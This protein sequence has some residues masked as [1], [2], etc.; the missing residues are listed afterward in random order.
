M[1]W[2]RLIPAAALLAACLAPTTLRGQEADPQPP[3]NDSATY[4]NTYAGGFTPGSGFDLVKTAGG[5]LNVSVYGLFRYMNQYAAGRSFTDHLGQ[6]REVEPRNDVNWHRTFVWVTGFVFDPKF[7]YSIS[8]WSLPTTQQTLLFGNLQYRVSP[9]LVIGAGLGPNLT[10]RSVQGSW[11]YWAA[12][13]R[14][15]SEEFFRGGFS[16]G[17]WLTGQALP[18]LYYTVSVNNNISQLGTTQASDT[19]NLAYSGSLKWLPTTGELGPRN[20]FGDLEFHERVAT[21]F[22]VSAATS[23]ESRYSPDDQAPNASQIRLSDGVNPFEVGALAPGVTVQTLTYDYLSFD[24]AA[25]YRGFSFQ[26]EYYFRK[27]SQ[28]VATGPVPLGSISDHGFMAEAMHMVV[29]K[30]LGAY[31]AT[32]YVFDAFERRPWEVATGVDFY[33]YKSRAWR[34]NL[35]LIHVEKSPTSSFFGYYTAGQTGTTFSLSTD[36]LL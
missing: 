9:K 6:V 35:H 14:Q 30:T 11:P 13:D 23:R 28:F 2:P 10:A 31:V 25:K 29:P 15:M 12:T 26:S 33:P 27:L 20:G 5:S 24:A 22:G 34:I 7:R 21:Q 32:G 16:S 4:A 18:R 36:I 17:V 8:L 1:K 19:P 3:A